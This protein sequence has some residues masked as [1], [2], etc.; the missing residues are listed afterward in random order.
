[1]R[2]RQR[3]RPGRQWQPVDEGGAGGPLTA[4]F[5]SIQSQVFTP[6]CAI[7]G[8]HA[9]ATAP[10]GLRLDAGSSYALLVGVPSD[11]VPGVMRVAP[12]DPDGSYVV[13]KLEGRPPSAS[14]CRSA[15]PISPGHDRRAAPVDR[16]GAAADSG[17]PDTPPTVV[18]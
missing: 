14:A 16:D 12:G 5:S 3:Q 11:E 6:N 13:Q 10:H 18:P 9:G 7:S 8:C 2:P 17:M 1:M 15:D 4:T